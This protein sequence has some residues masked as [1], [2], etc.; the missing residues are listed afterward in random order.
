MKPFNKFWDDSSEYEI[1]TDRLRL[2][3]EMFNLNG[4]VTPE[5][6]QQELCSDWITFPA[7]Q[8]FLDRAPICK[9]VSQLRRFIGFGEL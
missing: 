5:R 7:Y 8:E 1:G 6:A 4:F 9:I 2:V 3:V